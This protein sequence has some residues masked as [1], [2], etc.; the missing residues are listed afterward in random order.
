MLLFRRPH[1]TS[2][3]TPWMVF[4]L[5]AV[6]VFL[7]SLDATIVV[8]AFPSL[9]Q[10]FG[11][12]LAT[13]LSWI[14]NAY[15]IT[16]AA[17]LVPAG[18]LADLMGRKRLF[19]QGLLL[20]TL[21][22][23]LCGLAPSVWTLVAARF[24]QA[25]GAVLLTP[26]SL[27]LLL[28]AF[29]KEKRA[30][31]VSLWTV[32]GALAAAVG[33]AIGSW[34]I[35][36]SSWRWAFL[37]NLP[38]GLVAWWLSRRLLIESRNVP[39]G[40]SLDLT[41]VALLTAAGALLTLGIVNSEVWGWRSWATT[42]SLVAGIMAILSYIA[43][44][45]DRKDATV[46]LE[47]FEDRTYRFVTLATLVFGI[48]FSMMFLSSFL[49][50]M[51]IWKYSQS[52]TGLAVAMGPFVVMPVAIATGRWAARHGH[53]PV[54]VIGGVLYGVAQLWLWWRVDATPAYWLV[55]FPSQV[56]GGA[57]I[58]LLLP[59]LSAAAVV[60]LSPAR[61]GVGGAVNNAV[62]QLGGVLGTAI[63][64]VLVGAPNAPLSDYK[65]VFLV[66]AAVGFATALLSL[67]I[68]TR[69]APSFA[70]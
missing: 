25:L 56:M 22:S 14:L 36:A 8:A 38:I 23:L 50:L 62:R 40:A 24:V 3:P 68:D 70:H 26:A 7:V 64:V 30:I 32:V 16:T 54:L 19:L 34:V 43:W 67:P 4:R 39:L 33:P 60:R 59:G 10:E 58:G 48:A 65:Q 27:A 11:G 55:W 28:E 53:R 12:N 6:S 66:L 20:F 51:G 44:A 2:S 45:R 49:F 61:F 29:P 17:L 63:A 46:D 47:L 42:A 57:A 31:A 35:E 52:L 18:R 13:D 69:P 9:R 1:V 5:L 15:T 21:G 41:G 37:I